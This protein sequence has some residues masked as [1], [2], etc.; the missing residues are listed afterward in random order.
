MKEIDVERY[1]E[2]LP[3]AK[4]FH[5]Y[6]IFIKAKNL[7]LTFSI[8]DFDSDRLEIFHIIDGVINGGKA[9]DGVR[10]TKGR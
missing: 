8:S 10:P 6:S 3:L 2:L 9:N 7:G 4:Y 5:A 1:N